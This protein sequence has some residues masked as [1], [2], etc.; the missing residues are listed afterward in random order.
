MFACDV[1]FARYG[2]TVWITCGKRGPSGRSY[3]WTLPPRQTAPRSSLIIRAGGAGGRTQT[4]RT[5]KRA[6]DHAD[7]CASHGE[8][9]VLTCCARMKQVASTAVRHAVD[10]RRRAMTS[11]HALAT[12][13]YTLALFEDQTDG[14]MVSRPG[15]CTYDSH[16][17][18]TIEGSDQVLTCGASTTTSMVYGDGCMTVRH[19][20]RVCH[21]RSHSSIARMTTVANTTFIAH[22]D[23]SEDDVSS[24]RLMRYH[25]S[26]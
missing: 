26:S 1:F 22:V 16:H 2:S 4:H 6:I 23:R 21:T 7:W 20:C 19:V 11:A 5:R 14:G 10:G 25:A 13:M 3:A 9:P 12:G 15:L 18:S 8:Q 17:T 24:G